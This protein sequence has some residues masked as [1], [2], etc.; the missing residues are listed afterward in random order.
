MITALLSD[1]KQVRN[2]AKTGDLIKLG[3]MLP[4]K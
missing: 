2:G 3:L 4:I 1:S